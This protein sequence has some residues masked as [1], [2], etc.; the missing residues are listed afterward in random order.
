MLQ[1]VETK[2][3]KGLSV[4]L[5]PEKFSSKNRLIRVTAW[6]YRFI[7]NCRGKDRLK[8]AY[9]N[10]AEL[11]RA[12][13][14][15]IKEIQSELETQS[16][17]KQLTQQLNIVKVE[18]VLRCE[19]R[20][21]FSGLPYDTQ[22]PILLPKG[23]HFTELVVLEAHTNAF[24][25]GVNATLAEIRRKYW[26]PKGRQAVKKIIRECKACKKRSVKALKGNVTGPLPEARVKPARPFEAIG[27]DFAGPLLL[28]NDE[29]AYIALITC[30][31]TRAVHLELTPDMTAVEFQATLQRFIS[32]RGAPVTIISDNAK[33]FQST[34][35]QLKKI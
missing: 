17:Y 16:N 18:E 33:T 27:C 8:T 4:L 30:A 14:A 19:G 29:K 13:N 32:R 15:W 31:V 6:I 22:S 9:L 7:R 5:S 20:L 25:S 2:E 3:S 24:H 21:K 35:K 11:K 28:K 12:E 10:T 26:I 23:H 34:G 1:V